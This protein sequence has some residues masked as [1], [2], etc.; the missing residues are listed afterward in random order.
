MERLLNRLLGVKVETQERIFEYFEALLEHEVARQKKE[1]NHSGA[2]GRARAGAL[3]VTNRETHPMRPDTALQGPIP[4][5]D[6]PP[7]AAL[8]PPLLVDGIV[9]AKYEHI[10]VSRRGPQKLISGMGAGSDTILYEFEA[11][12]PRATRYTSWLWCPR[13][14][15]S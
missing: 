9:T 5:P 15:G 8:S 10:K 13:R 11:R 3:G 6:H 2:R 1:G 4:A 14:R 12:H 7:P